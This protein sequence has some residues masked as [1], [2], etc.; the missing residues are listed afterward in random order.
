MKNKGI[1][2]IS[3][4][5]L[6]SMNQVFA[7]KY[8]F[9]HI[10]SQKL[11]QQMPDKKT[12]EA[13]LQKF[14][15]ELEEQLELM[16]VEL[17]KKYQDY[18]TKRDSL[19]PLIRKAKEEELQD[20]Q[21]R[22]QNFQ[23]SAQQEIQKKEQELLTPI[24]EKAKKAIEEVAAEN[25]FTYIFDISLGVVLYKSDDSIDIMPLVKTKLGIE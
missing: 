22:V 13:E 21:E 18:L 23:M 20:M 4:I 8:K 1:L 15:S 11:L 25:G 24:I 5:L 19:S 2:L 16:Q 14:A 3:I 10:D 17:N 7:Q 6:F 12:A 9:G